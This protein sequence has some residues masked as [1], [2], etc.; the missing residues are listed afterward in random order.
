[1]TPT[2][3]GAFPG[4][5][6][7]YVEGDPYEYLWDVPN[8]YSALFSLLG[9]TARVQSLLTAYLSRP[10]GGGMYAQLTNEFDFG[11]QFALDYAGDPAGTQKAVANIRNTLYRPGPDTLENNDDTGAN[12]SAFIWEMLG[13]YPENPGHGTLVFASP[14]FPSET[15]HLGNG[16]RVHMNAP[17]ASPSTYYVQSLTLN[18]APHQNPFVNYSTLARGVTLNWTLGRAPTSW[19]AL[20]SQAPPSY[21]SG[22]RPAVGFIS[23][24]RVSL[25]PGANATVSFG[26]QNATAREQR[27]ELHIS[28]PA[29]SGV[30]VSPGSGTIWLAPDG[31]ATLDASVAAAASA[32]PGSDWVTAT[33]STPG[34]ATQ[35]VKL[36]V[37][38]G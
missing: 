1:M 23:A 27:V 7:P 29:G 12:S 37:A 24:R 16:K 38:V 15:I 8:D 6:E 32:P 3:A 17:G 21:T 4:D 36:A 20:P 10:N 31:R 34:D 33:V 5:Y 11:E 19:G 30:S 35:A 22:L 14:G 25:E 18:G 2:A 26:A 9:G 28:T 13:M